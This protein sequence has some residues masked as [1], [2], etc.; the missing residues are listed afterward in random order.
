MSLAAKKNMVLVVEDD[1]FIALDLEDVLSEAGFTVTGPVAT[2][3]EALALL[4]GEHRPDVALLDYN[5]GEETSIPVA[6]RLEA[7]GIPFLF[8]S[9]QVSSVVLGSTTSAP[10]VLSKPFVPNHLVNELGSLCQ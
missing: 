9:G 4:D 8:L 10:T 7:L 3:R 5:L 6:R 2:V 1:A